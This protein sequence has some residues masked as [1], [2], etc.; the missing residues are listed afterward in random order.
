MAVGVACDFQVCEVDHGDFVVDQDLQDRL[1]G[2]R[3]AVGGL[4]K[5]GDIDG[6]VTADAGKE[7]GPGD[8]GEAIGLGPAFGDQG[9]LWL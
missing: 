1:V 2:L 5:F 3:R 6:V 8:C 4:L 9:R 7:V